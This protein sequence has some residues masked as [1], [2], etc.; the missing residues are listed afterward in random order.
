[1][2]KRAASAEGVADCFRRTSARCRLWHG[3]AIDTNPERAELSADVL[4]V[5][6]GTERPVPS[7]IA[8]WLNENRH[9]V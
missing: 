2:E 6:Q 7:T 5:V 8:D 1:M 9:V 4:A 3:E